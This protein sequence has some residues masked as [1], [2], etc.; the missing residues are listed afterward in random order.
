MNSKLSR[1]CARWLGVVTATVAAV[2]GLPAAEAAPPAAPG[3][4]LVVLG[5]SFAANGFRWEADAKECLRGPTSW[6]TQLS[7]LMGV[8]GGSDFVDVSCSGAAIETERG[9]SLVQEAINADKAG[10]FGPRTKLIA[11][12]FGLNDTWGANPATLWTSLVPC[13]FNV[14]EGCGLE[15]AAQGRITD[16]RGVSGAQYAERIRAVVEYLRYYAPQAKVVLVG[17]PELF[18]AGQSFTCVSVLGVGQYVQP[19]G[20][21]LVEYLDRIDAAQR[22]AATQ[23]G[24]E[25]FDSRALTAGHGLCSAQPWLNGV[26]DPRADPVGIP[27]HPSAHGD[28]VIAGALYERYGK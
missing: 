12:Q 8:A 25:Y 2:A 18:P 5:D 1:R 24:I 28:S 20:A 16:Y 15:A 19:R 27:F 21:G 13:I 23:L 14:A 9:Y 4:A 26:L 10:A 3:S 7:R 17:Y 22:D 11:V 6:P